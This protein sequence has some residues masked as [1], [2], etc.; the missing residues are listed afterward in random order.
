MDFKEESFYSYKRLKRAATLSCVRDQI[1]LRRNSCLVICS[2]AG[3][4]CEMAGLG[5]RRC[6]WTRIDYLT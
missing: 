3:W 6:C 1:L 2:A 4:S 5:R